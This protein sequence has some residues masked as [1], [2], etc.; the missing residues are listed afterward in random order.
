MVTSLS[1]LLPHLNLVPCACPL[2]H[3]FACGT[4]ED[5]RLNGR[6]I[7]R[8][9]KDRAQADKGAYIC[10]SM[11]T[12]SN[13]CP[14]ARCAVMEPEQTNLIEMKVKVRK[15]YTKNREE[16]NEAKEGK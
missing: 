15:L 9:F 14:C 8:S 2:S 7:S 5:T 10:G 13:V 1:S 12:M 4:S 16:K 11:V 3:L 6:T